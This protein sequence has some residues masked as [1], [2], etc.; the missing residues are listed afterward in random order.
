MELFD[1]ASEAIPVSGDSLNRIYSLSRIFI[2][3]RFNSFGWVYE[4][5]DAAYLGVCR[6]VL[7]E[8]IHARS[9]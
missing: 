8:E 5:T 9:L 7:P 3:R 6:L 1:R 2:T 4:Y